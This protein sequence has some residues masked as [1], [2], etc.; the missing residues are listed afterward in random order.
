MKKIV[1]NENKI[2]TSF[3]DL[4]EI[5]SCRRK[6]KFI[7]EKC[8]AQYE[9]AIDVIL[10]KG[11]LLC[12]QCSTI[13]TNLSKYGVERPAQNKDVMQKMKDTSLARY[14]V[15]NYF[16][17]EEGRNIC[18]ETAL[19]ES[20]KEARRQGFLTKYGVDNPGK[21]PGRTFKKVYKVDGYTF[22]STWEMLFYERYLKNS[23]HNYIV[24]PDV[25][26]EYF[27]NGKSHV[28]LP[29]FFVDGSYIDI[30]ADFFFNEKGEM[31]NPWDLEDKKP[32]ARYKCMMEN[33]VKVLKSKELKEL[34]VL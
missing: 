21:I 20:S 25:K 32:A 34:G 4:L 14:G 19:K 10:R 9:Y 6:C 18:R 23:N 1:F 17:T 22:D 30:K 28:Y 31:I 26:F 24:H 7:C 2:F 8:N 27:Y 11:K 15:E 29:D 5:G 33:N 16:Q 3:N 13:E 12:R